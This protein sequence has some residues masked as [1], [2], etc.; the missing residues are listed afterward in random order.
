[1]TAAATPPIPVNAR[2]SAAIAEMH[3]SR[4]PRCQTRT[5]SGETSINPIAI[6]NRQPTQAAPTASEHA[7][8]RQP[9]AGTRQ[10]TESAEQCCEHHIWSG[11]RPMPRT[12]GLD[13]MPRS[14]RH[15]PPM[16]SFHR[17]TALPALPP[18]VPP[19]PPCRRRARYHSG[20]DRK[21]ANMAPGEPIQLP[22]MR[23]PM[24]STT[25]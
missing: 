15:R 24:R 7:E 23:T 8:I 3:P 21:E 4:A 9:G 13:F 11:A 22:D 1:M 5:A 2:M 19:N 25:V 12:I 6:Q 14:P 10:E 18:P 17:R 16:Q 20:P